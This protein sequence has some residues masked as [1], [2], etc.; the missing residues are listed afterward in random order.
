MDAAA[1]AAAS[2]F[3]HL[4]EAQVLTIGSFKQKSL[5]SIPWQ[6]TCNW[7]SNTSSTNDYNI[8]YSLTILGHMCVPRLRPRTSFASY[9]SGTFFWVGLECSRTVFKIDPLPTVIC[10][11][12]A[13]LGQ[14]SVWWR[15]EFSIVGRHNV[16]EAGALFLVEVVL[17]EKIHLV[18]AFSFS[19]CLGSCCRYLRYCYVT[20][21]SSKITDNKEVHAPQKTALELDVDTTTWWQL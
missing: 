3:W 7:R 9:T 21:M 17:M 15:S 6:L 20:G 8:I 2:T 12:D 10:S 14:F 13:V 4:D 18:F 11:L 19:R 16:F 1:A 5:E